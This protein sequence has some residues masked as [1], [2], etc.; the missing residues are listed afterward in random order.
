[1]DDI[2]SYI[3]LDEAAVNSL[4]AQL[5]KKIA[6][7]KTIKRMQGKAASFKVGAGLSKLFGIFSPDA[8]ANRERSYSTQTDIE[9]LMLP[10]DRVPR[11]IDALA[12]GKRYYTELDAAA[13]SLDAAERTSR[14]KGG[15]F[16][17][18]Y[19]TFHTDTSVS[20]DAGYTLFERELKSISDKG[21][22][23]GK[24]IMAMSDSNLTMHKLH[25]KI[26]L[27]AGKDG[28]RMGVFG[29]LRKLGDGCFQIKPFA[30]WW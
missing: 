1:M 10:Q 13:E 17:N 5:R 23:Q 9:Y 3:Y 27:G 4:Y 14:D 22:K 20:K 25:I 7:K 11:V 2:K 29:Q 21:E 24:I 12:S 30:V 6:V 8:S 16:V 19:D 28:M 15:V 26:A 18:V